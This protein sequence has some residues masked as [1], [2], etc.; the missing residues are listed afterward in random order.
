MSESELEIAQ[1][2]VRECAQAVARQSAIIA[3]LL[4]RRRPTGLETAILTSLMKSQ[5]E[6]KA[7]LDRLLPK[8]GSYRDQQSGDSR[9]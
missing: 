4:K 8:G 1:R 5:V 7:H 6:Y 9:P 3:D 2:R